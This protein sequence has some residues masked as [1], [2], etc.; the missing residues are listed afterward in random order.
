MREPAR[1]SHKS[2]HS[3]NG[4]SLTGFWRIYEIHRQVQQG[5]YPNCATLA[6]DLEVHRRTIERDIGRLKDFFGAP[7]AYD[8]SKKGYYYTDEFNLPSMRLREGEAVALLLGQKILSQCKGTP[9]EQSVRDAMNKV[10]LLMPHEMEDNLL[11]TMESVSFHVEPL[12]GEEPK[13][14]RAYETL[15]RA[16]EERRTVSMDYFSPSRRRLTERLVDPYHLRLVDGAW[17][18]IGYCHERQEV[19]TFAL[20]RITRIALTDSSFEVQPGFSIEKY[21]ADSLTIERG[22][23]RKVVIEFSPEEAVYIQGRKWHKSQIL[24]VLPDGGLRMTLTIGG[25]GEV[26]RWVMSMGP[27]AW[28]REPA[29][30]KEEIRRDLQEALK[31]YE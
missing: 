10:R 15:A 31:R 21:L 28:V 3:D 23:P 25:L 20:D 14:V 26:K 7:L 1:A 13:V 19:R 22:E 2:P 24:E 16:I 27:N 4:I 17:Y 11:R 5:K 9:F 6:R 29:D 18:C 8:P 30:L 12:R